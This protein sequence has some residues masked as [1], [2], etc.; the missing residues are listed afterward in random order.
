MKRT[1]AATLCGVGGGSREGSL[2][3]PSCV[4]SGVGEFEPAD[5]IR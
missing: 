4:S 2:Q 5:V 1:E 3:I